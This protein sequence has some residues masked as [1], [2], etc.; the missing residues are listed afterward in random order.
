MPRPIFLTR[1]QRVGLALREGLSFVGTVT[2]GLCAGMIVAGV[3][4]GAFRLFG[5]VL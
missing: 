2:A 1:T 5:I 3:I 4:V